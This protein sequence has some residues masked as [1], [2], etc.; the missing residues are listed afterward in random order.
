VAKINADDMREVWLTADEPEDTRPICSHCNKHHDGS[1][2]QEW[3]SP[4]C[5]ILAHL[6]QMSY[7]VNE[8]TTKFSSYESVIRVL[9]V[10]GWFDGVSDSSTDRWLRVIWARMEAN[11]AKL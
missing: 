4:R 5:E 2:Y 3:C 1:H 11:K 7:F 6:G 8:F 10:T 9:T